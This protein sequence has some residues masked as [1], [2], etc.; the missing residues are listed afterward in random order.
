MALERGSMLLI[1]Q[2][3]T[4]RITILVL[5]SRASDSESTE[6]NLIVMTLK[7]GN[8]LFKV[9]PCVSPWRRPSTSMMRQDEPKLTVMN[10]R[11]QQASGEGPD[12]NVVRVPISADPE[13]ATMTTMSPTLQV[14]YLVTVLVVARLILRRQAL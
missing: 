5:S 13:L 2:V 4:L 3:W 14:Q 12:A 11:S 10:R 6:M 9:S 7:F 8:Y 1:F